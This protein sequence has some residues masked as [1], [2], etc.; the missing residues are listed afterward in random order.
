VRRFVSFTL[1]GVI[2]L[3]LVAAFKATEVFAA[4][5]QERSIPASFSP[6]SL[7]AIEAFAEPA[8]GYSFVPEAIDQARERVWLVMYELSDQSVIAALQAAH[9]RGVDVRV[10]LDSSYHGKD[11]NA[12]AFDELR[13]AGVPVRWAPPSTLLHQKTLLVD[14][15]AWIM[16]GNLMPQYY[17]SS[18][19]FVVGDAQPQ[20]VAEIAA[21]FVDDWDGD[22]ASTPY[23]ARVTGAH[24][25]LLF[26]PLSESTLLGLINQA[27]PGT[28]LLTE[29]EEMDNYAIEQA[30][31]R[32]A[33]RGVDVKVVMTRSYPW[34]SA[35]SQLVAGGVHVATYAYD[36][37][38][39]IHAKALVINND[40]AYV[41]SI[42]YSTA[43]MIYNRE[44]GI[45]TRNPEVVK[46]V[47]ATID[48]DFAGAQPWR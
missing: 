28:T 37:P 20:D 31:E 44:L 42:N 14:T 45:V 35:F 19:D 26:S 8:Y 5:E 33:R 29:S 2:A 22:L 40:V 6:T 38:I 46:E 36:A 16:T 10:L 47:T 27:R 24:G 9:R 7:H 43:S 1:C 21:A 25:D 12:G 41:G 3:A 18:V 34:Y 30:L 48:A 13:A 39:Y 11:V 4:T 17:R 32:A 15:R 23:S